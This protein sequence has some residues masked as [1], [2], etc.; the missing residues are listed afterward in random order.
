MLLELCERIGDYLEKN[1]S[2]GVDFEIY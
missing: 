1:V 2:L